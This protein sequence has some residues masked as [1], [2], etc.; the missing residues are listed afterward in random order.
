MNYR[1]ASRTCNLHSKMIVYDPFMIHYDH[2]SSF[3]FNTTFVPYGPHLIIA[4]VSLS[5]RTTGGVVGAASLS[6]SNYGPNHSFFIFS[7]LNGLQDI[8]LKVISQEPHYVEVVRSFIQ[9]ISH[10]NRTTSCKSHSKIPNK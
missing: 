6:N 5:R 3:I 7:F 10:R 4:Y 9:T 1:S 8:F 2:L